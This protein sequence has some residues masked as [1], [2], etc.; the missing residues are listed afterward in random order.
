MKN[1]SKKIAYW[2]VRLRPIRSIITNRATGAV[3]DRSLDD[4]VKSG[5]QLDTLMRVEP[6]VGM[7]AIT[8][9]IRH[10]V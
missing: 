4:R 6:E 1:L 5:L 2:D 10:S 7:L 8:F 9:H 3:S